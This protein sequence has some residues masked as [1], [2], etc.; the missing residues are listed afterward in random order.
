MEKKLT[1]PEFVEGFEE[2]IKYDHIYAVYQPQINHSTKRMIGAEALM[3]WK[4]P[5]FGVQMPGDF[6]P[7]LEKN[8]LIFMPFPEKMPG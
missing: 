8:N 2:A 6:I 4:H 7:V 1:E 3:R 5:V